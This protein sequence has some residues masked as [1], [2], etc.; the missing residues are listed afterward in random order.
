MAVAAEMTAE[1]AVAAT[2]TATVAMSAPATEGMSCIPLHLM[3][4]IARPFA[5]TLAE[6]RWHDCSRSPV[7]R[8]GS[9][10]YSPARPARRSPSYGGRR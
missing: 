3:V 8:R 6:M 4:Y 1:A 9:P 2:E 5:G 7:Q 10:A